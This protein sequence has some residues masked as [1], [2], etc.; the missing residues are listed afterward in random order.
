MNGNSKTIAARLALAASAALALAGGISAGH[1]ETA[2][3]L[4]VA[5]AAPAALGPATRFEPSDEA[6]AE[7]GVASLA[8]AAEPTAQEA[9]SLD[10]AAPAAQPLGR[11]VASFYGRQFAGRPTA[12]GERFDPQLLTAAHRTLPFGSQVRVTNNRNG[13]SVVV[14][15]NDRGPFHGSRT[16]DL[17]RRA[18]EQIGIVSAGHG[19]VE[20]ELLAG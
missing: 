13:R 6:S 15:I 1:A 3:E 12:S 18:A 5:L 9:P 2:A 17:S 11:G 14:R 8:I 4:P 19:T 10:T 20:L 7:A 16:I